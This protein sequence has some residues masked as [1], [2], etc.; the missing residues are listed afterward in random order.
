MSLEDSPDS[1]RPTVIAAIIQHFI[2]DP[3]HII[4]AVYA[5]I[6]NLL[7]LQQ[8]PASTVFAIKMEVSNDI[9]LQILA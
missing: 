8:I 1:E 6:F 7:L 3:L 9:P 4:Q 5:F 2:Q